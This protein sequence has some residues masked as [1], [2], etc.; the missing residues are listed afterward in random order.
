MVYAVDGPA[1]SADALASAAL[2]SG[3]S[4]KEPVLYQRVPGKATS[5]TP[6]AES[7]LEFGAAYAWTVRAEGGS[8]TSEWSEI[9]LFR[10]GS[11]PT[12]AEVRKALGTLEAYLAREDASAEVLRSGLA[13]LLPGEEVQRR[14]ASDGDGEPPLPS[15]PGA[16]A[17]G[18]KGQV[19]SGI[20]VQ[21][22]GEVSANVTVT[23]SNGVTGTVELPSAG[24]VSRVE[25]PPG[26]D[27]EG[28]VALVTL[29]NMQ[30]GL[31]MASYYGE[32]LVYSIQNSAVE[33]DTVIVNYQ[34]NVEVDGKVT[35][36]NIPA[37]SAGV[38]KLSTH[39]GPPAGSSIAT[40]IPDVRSGDQAFVWALLQLSN[41]NSPTADC[42]ID[43]FTVVDSQTRSQSLAAVVLPN[44]QDLGQLVVQ[45]AITFP[46]TAPTSSIEAQWSGSC[47]VANAWLLV[48]VLSSGHSTPDPPGLRK[49]G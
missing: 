46:A 19:F 33:T 34:G 45:D 39:A 40:T 10:I 43:A 9:Q 13:D 48:E 22:V 7:C 4:G 8:G 17:W 37:G 44:E 21:N 11:K 36:E 25:G 12:A 38:R 5:W 24:L 35:S 23:Y 6:S 1:V 28:G 41:P 14:S 20:T 27:G 2:L 30:S 26:V 42:L 3:M 31:H 32:N 47:D 16:S 18:G 49:E 15:Q 29:N